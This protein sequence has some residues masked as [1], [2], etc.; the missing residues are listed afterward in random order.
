MKAQILFPLP[1]SE[2]GYPPTNPLPKGSPNVPKPLMGQN[3]HVT[4]SGDAIKTNKCIETCRCSM[5]NPLKA[6]RHKASRAQRAQAVVR[7]NKEGHRGLCLAISTDG[8]VHT[9][10]PGFHSPCSPWGSSPP[11]SL[12]IPHRSPVVHPH[13]LYHGQEYPPNL[14][15]SLDADMASL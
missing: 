1:P 14:E 3:D 9:K 10:S 12:F 8:S 2:A 15:V 13:T 4:S 11:Y 7:R 6:K 5:E